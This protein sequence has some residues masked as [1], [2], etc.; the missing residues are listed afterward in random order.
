MRPMHRVFSNIRGRR[1]GIGAWQGRQDAGRSRPPVGAPEQPS[2]D[3]LHHEA[4]KESRSSK[5]GNPQLA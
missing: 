4:S 3:L 5:P 2:C 1:R